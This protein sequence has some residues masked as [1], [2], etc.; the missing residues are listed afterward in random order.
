[1]Q[2]WLKQPLV[3]LGAINQRLDVVDAFVGDATLRDAL[4]DVH[5][6]GVGPLG[7]G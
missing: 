6:R 4:R 7:L 1:M 2:V 5:L 3:D